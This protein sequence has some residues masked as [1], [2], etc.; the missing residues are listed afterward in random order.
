[1]GPSQ[2][3]IIDDQEYLHPWIKIVGWVAALLL[4][5]FTK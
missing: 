1:M 3:E 2:N 5:C 4:R